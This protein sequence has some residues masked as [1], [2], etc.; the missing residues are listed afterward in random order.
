MKKLLSA[1][2]FTIAYPIV[3]NSQTIAYDKGQIITKNNDTIK[4]LVELTPTYDGVV[5]YKTSP[6]SLFKTINIK[7]IKTVKT[8]YNIFQN[9]IIKKDELLFRTV[10]NGQTSLFEYSKINIGTS[11]NA[12]GGTMTTYRPPTII[13]A[14]KTNQDVYIIKEKKDLSQ[15]MYLLDK[16]P[17]AKA[18][19][20]NKEFKL[21]ELK[22]VITKINTC[23]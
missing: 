9:I 11:S 3:L 14:V 21:E 1:I 19:V 15:I 7:K 5:H 2:L 13:Y 6:N 20:D 4:A 10:I 16:C 18:I 23:K 22:S 12:Y 17:D 8:P